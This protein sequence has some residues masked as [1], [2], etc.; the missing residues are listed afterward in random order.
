MAAPDLPKMASAAAVRVAPGAVLLNQFATSF[1][2][3]DVGR[4]CP[5]AVFAD[6]PI[7]ANPLPPLAICFDKKPMDLPNWPM[8]MPDS[9]ATPRSVDISSA[10][11]PITRCRPRVSFATFW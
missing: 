7:A 1:S 8:S 3:A 11:P 2:T 5:V 6:T 4:I 10:V 9:F